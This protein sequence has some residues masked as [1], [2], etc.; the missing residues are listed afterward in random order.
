MSGPCLSPDVAGHALTPAT[1]RCLGRPLPHQQ[2]DRTWTAPGSPELCPQ[3]HAIPRGHQVLATL[4]QREPKLPPLSL[5]PGYVI[6]ALLTRSPLTYDRVT[7]NVDPFDLH[8]LATP[9]A[10]V[11]SQDQTLQLIIV[12]FLQAGLPT[13]RTDSTERLTFSSTL[14]RMQAF[15]R[16][17]KA[18]ILDRPKDRPH[19]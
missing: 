11:L 10:F 16:H 12:S 8:A 9:P 18:P 3:N 7:P 17:P 13:Q 1:R 14:V 15:G 4:S 19:T 5:N 6:H 2:A